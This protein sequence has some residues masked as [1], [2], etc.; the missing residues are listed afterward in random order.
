MNQPGLVLI[1]SLLASTTLAQSVAPPA[2]ALAQ[3]IAI[4]LN[5]FFAMAT[6]DHRYAA[7]ATLSGKRLRTDTKNRAS[8]TSAT[9]SER[10]RDMGATRFYDVAGFLPSTFPNFPA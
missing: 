3:E 4:K 7:K 1:L 9:P 2:S 8:S 6:I 10:L 5:S